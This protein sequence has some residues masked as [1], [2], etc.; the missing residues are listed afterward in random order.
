MAAVPAPT[1][2][3]S[4]DDVVALQA[5]ADESERHKWAGCCR[6]DA[7]GVW[8]DE[9]SRPA[10]PHCPC[11]C[12]GFTVFAEHFCK[13][14]LI[15]LGI[16]RAN[17]LVKLIGETSLTW[18]SIGTDEYERKIPYSHWPSY[19]NDEHIFRPE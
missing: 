19:A 3:F 11:Q 12:V 1:S 10:M 17:Q 4:V 6:K 13:K 16:E 15:W 7:S 14:C 9:W 18:V 8:L 5:T 2:P